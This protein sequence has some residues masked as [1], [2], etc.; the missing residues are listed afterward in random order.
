MKK[1]SFNDS[2]CVIKPL[3]PSSAIYE[4]LPFTGNLFK[5]DRYRLTDERFETLLFIN[6]NKHFKH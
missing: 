5:L 2:G 3:Q 1:I 6:C 4:A